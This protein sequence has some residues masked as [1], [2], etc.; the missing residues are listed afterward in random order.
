MNYLYYFLDY[1]NTI[2][3]I[4]KTGNIKRRM[5]E[6]F[7]Q[8]HL[9]KECYDNVYQIMYACVNDS[10]YDTEICETLM[11]D[12]YKP[13]FNIDKKFNE[14]KDK[15]SFKL[16]DLNF[17]PLYIDFYDDT[18]EISDKILKPQYYHSKFSLSE[19]GDIFI[20]YNCGNIIHKPGMF[21]NFSKNIYEEC[22]EWLLDNLLKINANIKKYVELDYC[23]FDEPLSPSEDFFS[24]GYIAFNLDIFENINIPIKHILTLANSGFIFKI[25]ND[26]YATPLYTKYSLQKIN[27]LHQFSGSVWE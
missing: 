23:D 5:K 17:K 18:L 2:I 7:L 26:I 27:N 13:I 11:I 20:S 24:E 14:N 19:K 16:P 15:T 25:T 6:H 4:G 1:N 22:S 3:Y 12:K 8:G 10:K 9:P 21:K